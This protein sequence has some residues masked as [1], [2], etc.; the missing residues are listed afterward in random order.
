MRE[1]NAIGKRCPAPILQIAQSLKD[2]PTETRFLLSADDP[3]TSIDIAA[4]A[5]MTGNQLVQL[6]ATD[7][8]ITRIIP[9]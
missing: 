8:L 9:S 3:A 4:W 2:H 5:R 6:S 1:V 7:F